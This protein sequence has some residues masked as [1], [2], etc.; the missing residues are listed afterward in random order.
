MEKVIAIN[1]TAPEKMTV[2]WDVGRRCNFDCTYCESSRHNL[3]SP[4]TDYDE[5]KKTFEFIKSYAALYNQKKVNINFTGG[6]PTVNPKFWDLSYH[7]YQSGIAELGLTTNGTYDPKK[8]DII[9]KYF[10]SVT[11]SWHAESDKKI[12]DKVLANI[13]ALHKIGKPVSVNVMMHV[14]YWSEAVKVYTYLKANGV[15]CNPVPI[16][17]GNLGYT[18]WFLDEEG[19]NR[20]TGHKYDKFQQEWFWNANGINAQTAKKIMAGS[21]IGRTCCGGRCLIGKKNNEWQAIKMIDTRFKDWFCTINYYFLHIEQHTGNVY[22]H[23]TCKATFTG[24]GPIGNLKDTQF[25][26]DN[27]KAYL[28]NPKPIVCPNDR[29]GCGMCVPKAKNYDDFKPM[30]DNLIN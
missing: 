2:T 28:E 3:Y 1:T 8:I 6:E 19:I 26:L 20:R 9:Q 30:W 15:R 29:C 12:R 11:V 24:K 23:Q 14:D 5:L 22:H 7:V 4:P 25:I 16:G 18:D 21:D 27:T 17:D 13:M 10:N